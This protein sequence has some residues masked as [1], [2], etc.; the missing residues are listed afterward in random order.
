MTLLSFVVGL[1]L[2]LLLGAVVYAW[3]ERRRMGGVGPELMPADVPHVVD[4]LRRAHQAAAACLVIPEGEP[5]LSLG[6]PV[7]PDT[8]VDRAIATARLSLADGREHVLREGNVIVAV[9][10]GQ[11]GSAVVL[12]FDSVAPEDVRQVADDLRKFLAELRVE[13]LREYRTHQDPAGAPDWMVMGAESVEAISFGLCESVRALTGRHAAVVVRDPAVTE[14]SVVA[15]SRQAD[16][17]LLGLQVSPDSA[18]GR[19]CSGDI[20]VAGA[21]PDDLFGRSHADRRRRTDPGTAFPLHDGAEGC[22]AL[23]VFGPPHTLE[24]SVQERIAFMTVDAG[25]RLNN[26]VKV[27]AAETQA[28]T[29]RLTQ[30]PNRAALE[31][32]LKNWGDDPGTLLCVD[33]DRF[34]EV[35]DTHG[36]AAGDAA[37]KHVARLF[38]QALRDDDLATRIGGEE[39]AIWLPHT[40][41][42]PALDVAERI[43]KSVEASVL[44]WGGA[45]LT[46]T[47][48]V[49]VSTYP[50]IVSDLKNLL[51]SADSALYQAKNRGRNRVEAAAGTGSR[52]PSP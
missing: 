52:A 19:A 16:R 4:L 50:Q 51:P 20:P 39:F 32:A 24:P 28:M 6:E 45:E 29:D 14:A 2:G 21:S 48:S 25:P 9:G 33:I 10:D 35:N 11:I 47:C 36:H 1:V 7:P 26:A 27:R 23:V 34:K 43:R 37:L 15:V 18:V 3:W 44:R 22:G 13:R 42:Q 41:L 30:L 31:G 40:P 17:R 5:V 49:G 46:I 12:A 8:L 38:R